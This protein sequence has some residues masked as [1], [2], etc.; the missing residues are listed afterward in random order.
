MIKGLSAKMIL[1]VCIFATFAISSVALAAS[2]NVLAIGA[3]NTVGKGISASEAWP[4][5]L[6]RMLKA[7]GY[8][9]HV[10]VRAANGLTSREI[11]S[12]AN[13]IPSGT[14]VVIYELGVSNDRRRNVPLAESNA[15]GA[16]IVRL[17]R[18]QGAA[19]IRA[20]FGYL[21]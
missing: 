17:I 19:A 8:D 15:N 10:A 16:Q 1:A 5:V 21:T 7:K 12:Y 9:A 13:S 11:M 14:Q 20:P 18:A 6:E 4:A 2:V 3:S